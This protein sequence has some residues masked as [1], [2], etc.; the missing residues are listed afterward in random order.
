MLLFPLVVSLAGCGGDD[1]GV[2][3]TQFQ[4]TAS[5][6]W[7][8]GVFQ[9]SAGYKNRCATPRRGTSDRRGSVSD[10]NN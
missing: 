8:Q 2:D 3:K 10:Q 6:V 9:P 1:Q 7:R 5:S 4:G